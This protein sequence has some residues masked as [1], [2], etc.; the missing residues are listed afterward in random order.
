M[1]I[2]GVT[3]QEAGDVKDKINAIKLDKNYIYGEGTD[4]DENM[5]Y[6]NA[7]SDLMMFLNELRIGASKEPLNASDITPYLQSLS[8]RRGDGYMSFVYAE[9]AKCMDISPKQSRGIVA[10]NDSQAKP[11]TKEPPTPPSTTEDDSSASDSTLI[12]NDKRGSIPKSE[13]ENMITTNVLDREMF[14]NVW[15]YLTEMQQKG[16][17]KRIEKARSREEIPADAYV[18]IVD[19]DYSVCA[20]LSPVSGNQR[21]N[22]KTNRTDSL[23]NYSN[24]AFVWYK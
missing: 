16:D 12:K 4:T 21:V 11:K 19:R 7:V 6:Q 22:L 9:R 15:Q 24:V 2:I 14:P 23:H 13:T 10:K 5:S 17:I 18:I 8:Y 20:L 3:A 1:Q